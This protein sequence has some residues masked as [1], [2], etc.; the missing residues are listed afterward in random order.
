MKD[1]SFTAYSW[2]AD[3]VKIAG[4]KTDSSVVTF[5][6]VDWVEPNL[7]LCPY[8][9]AKIDSYFADEGLVMTCKHEC[10]GW[11]REHEML[12]KIKSLKKQIRDMQND[13]EKSALE[14]GVRI[15]AKEYASH[16]GERD[17]FDDEVAQYGK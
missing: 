15:F 17:A 6:G 13:I 14:N 8:C 10:E 7:T 2:C 12:L 1:D 11:Q 9:G 4:D 3:H 5:E 16:Q